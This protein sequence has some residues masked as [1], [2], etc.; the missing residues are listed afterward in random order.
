MR[1]PLE[2]GSLGEIE[3][4]IKAFQHTEALQGGLGAQDKYIVVPGLILVLAS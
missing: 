4:K 2:W 3:H 1:R